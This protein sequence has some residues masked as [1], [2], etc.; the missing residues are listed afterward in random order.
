MSCG[1]CRLIQQKKIVTICEVQDF[2]SNTGK[3]YKLKTIIKE[4]TDFM[5]ENY[6]ADDKQ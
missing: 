4:V 1:Y 3:N 2:K 6:T 5:Y